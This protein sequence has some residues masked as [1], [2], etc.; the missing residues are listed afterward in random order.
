MK[1]IQLY[2]IFMVSNFQVKK[3]L[4]SVQ[5]ER[6]FRTISKFSNSQL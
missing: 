5:K 4:G 3:L 6:N 2:G 1:E